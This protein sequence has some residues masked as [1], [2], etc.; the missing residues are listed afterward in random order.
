MD[1]Y[2]CFD[3]VDWRTVHGKNVS[4][5]VLSQKKIFPSASERGINGSFF[6]IF[7][8]TRQWIVFSI[9]IEGWS[10]FPFAWISRPVVAPFHS[11]GKQSNGQALSI[12]RSKVNPRGGWEDNDLKIWSIMLMLMLI[13]LSKCMSGLKREKEYI[14]LLDWNLKYLF[15]K[16]V[17]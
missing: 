4:T 9:C 6:C 5:L 15:C 16:T 11:D 7:I 10:V 17:N 13:M 8:F 14:L 3:S 1:I 12:T 2:W